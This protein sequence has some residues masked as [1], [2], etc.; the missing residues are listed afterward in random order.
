MG[1][2]SVVL[3]F[4]R[5]GCGVRARHRNAPC[6]RFVLAAHPIHP[7]VACRDMASC[8]YVCLCV[9]VDYFTEDPVALTKWGMERRLE[10]L[11]QYVGLGLWPLLPAVGDRSR[12]LMLS[13]MTV[14]GTSTLC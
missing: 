6:I 11:L 10:A 12:I 2:P 14:Q 7:I 1:I 3:H 13:F 9:I 8:V 4:G 5:L